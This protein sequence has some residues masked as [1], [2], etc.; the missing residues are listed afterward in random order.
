MQKRGKQLLFSSEFRPILHS[1]LVSKKLNNAGLFD[2]L[3]YQTVHTPQTIAEDIE[4]LP[5]GHYLKV[6]DGETKAFQYWSE[7]GQYKNVGADYEKVK[8]NINQ[9][10]YESVERRLVA[11]VPV[12]AFLS[13]G[14]DSS[15]VVGAMSQISDGKINTFNVSFDNSEFSESKYARKIADKFSTEHTEIVLKPNDFLKDLPNALKAMDHPSGDGPNTYT[16]SKATKNQGITVALSGLGGDELFAGY[17]IFKRTVSL[18][19]KRWLMSFPKF[20]RKMAGTAAKL[21]KPS[22]ASDK[23]AEIL[24]QD[25]LYPEYTYPFSRLVFLDRQL[26]QITNTMNLPQNRV[27][28]IV[29]DKI[30]VGKSGYDF[31]LLS[32]VSFAEMNTYYKMYYCAIRIKCQWRMPGS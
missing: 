21:T 3:R 17:D 11:D 4:Q 10:F 32:K 12:G 19:G 22:V 20:F 18:D 9:L 6:S 29:K 30:G 16:V 8:A 2:Y 13:G 1:G 23:I 14:I 31:P 28:E 7:S 27:F 24:I 26:L 15:A 25:Y 5:A